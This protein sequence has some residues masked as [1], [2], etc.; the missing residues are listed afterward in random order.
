M[1]KKEAHLAFLRK[2]KELLSDDKAIVD[3]VNK[4]LDGEYSDT[5]IVLLNLNKLILDNTSKL[6]PEEILKISDEK[7]GLEEIKKRAKNL[8]LLKKLGQEA[9]SLFV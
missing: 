9:S 3:L 6:A 1:A 7:N 2:V 5:T 8:V 4:A